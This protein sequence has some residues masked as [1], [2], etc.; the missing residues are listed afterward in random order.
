MVP[1]LVRRSPAPHD[2]A[3]NDKPGMIPHFWTNEPGQLMQHMTT[4]LRFVCTRR[5]PG[6]ATSANW[7][8]L[9][10]DQDADENVI[11]AEAA[12][13]GMKPGDYVHYLAETS[14]ELA[15]KAE[16]KNPRKRLRF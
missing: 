5:Q 6:P 13:A 2:A 7:D 14:I 12:I 1:A 11:E 8:A 15:D 16:R 9:V 4:G 3:M 10:L